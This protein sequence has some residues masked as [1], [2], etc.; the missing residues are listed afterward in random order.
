MLPPTPV[1]TLTQSEAVS[2]LLKPA[3]SF[4]M[5]YAS[6]DLGVQMFSIIISPG[7]VS[8]AVPQSTVL[9]NSSSHRVFPKC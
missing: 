8:P 1:L 4:T 7:W 6:L 9:A 5:V 3:D 2:L